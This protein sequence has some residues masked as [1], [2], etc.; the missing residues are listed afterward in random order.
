MTLAAAP[1]HSCGGRNPFLATPA[2]LKAGT[3]TNINPCWGAGRAIAYD[4]EF[5]PKWEKLRR[6]HENYVNSL[7][8]WGVGSGKV[9]SKA[10][11]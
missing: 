7:A 8:S 10:P 6:G 11:V 2:K 1:C 3:G 9:A 4:I 5:A